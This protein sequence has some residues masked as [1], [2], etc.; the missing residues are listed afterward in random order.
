MPQPRPLTDEE[1]ATYELQIWVD[2]HEMILFADGRAIVR[3]TTDP[4][5][6]KKLYAQYVGS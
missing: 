5:L 2:D 4:I 1:K 6:A 3:G